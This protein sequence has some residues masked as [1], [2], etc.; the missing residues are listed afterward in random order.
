[1]PRNH[2]RPL[3]HQVRNQVLELLSKGNF[4]PGAQIPSEQKLVDLL[5]VS[6]ATVR[7]ALQLLEQERVIRSR[8]GSGRFL[9]ATPQSI[10]VDIT[11]LQSVTE[12]LAEHGIR[13]TARVISAET[14]PASAEQAEHLH[15]AAGAPVVAIERIRYAQDLP[16]IYSIDI[17]PGHRFPAGWTA[18]DLQGSLLLFLERAGINVDHAHSTIRAVTLDEAPAA[19][20]GVPLD[21]CWILLEQ[22]NYSV[23]GEPLIYSRDYHRGDAIHFHVMRYRR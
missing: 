15:L 3:R 10:A 16:V 22:I 19:R 1:M 9:V 17:L 12:L 4:Q 14:L 23:S 20:V 18:A 6:R 2:R 5:D 11:Q 7:E 8:H 21:T 13:A